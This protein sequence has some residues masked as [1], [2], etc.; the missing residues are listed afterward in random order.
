MDSTIAVETITQMMKE[1]N[2]SKSITLAAILI[3]FL[4][5]SKV[6]DS[7]TKRNKIV[8][9]DKLASLIEM[10][11]VQFKRQESSDRE[12]CRM[13]IALSFDSFSKNIFDF[14]REII[15]NNNVELK[16]K[17]IE[18]SIE[19]T[20]NAEYYKLFNTL[21]VFEVNNHRVSNFMK[22]EWR[23]EIIAS[24]NL[25]IFDKDLDT[26]NKLTTLHSKLDSKISDYSAY[27]HNR[28]FNE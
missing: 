6:I 1:D 21:Y 23:A 4:V 20:V 27:I 26:I 11:S 16:R 12:K 8:L 5:I 13:T 22:A 7:R 2:T 25:I 15:I 3:I 14:G 18:S 19:T 10:L 9:S 17:Y 24:M 28:T